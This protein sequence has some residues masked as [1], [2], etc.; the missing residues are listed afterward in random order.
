MRIVQ[1]GIAEVAAWVIAVTRGYTYPGNHV[2]LDGMCLFGRGD[3]LDVARDAVC[4]YIWPALKDGSRERYYK[5]RRGETGV[6]V[7]A[8][9]GL[10]AMKMARRVGP[11]GR[12]VAVEPVRDNFEILKL[13]RDFNQLTWLYVVN[14]AVSSHH[15]EK[16]LSFRRE[17]GPQSY[18]DKSV[19]GAGG[20]REIVVDAVSLDEVL[21]PLG[22][23]DFLSLEMNGGEYAAVRGMEDYF[24]KRIYCACRYCGDPRREAITVEL[25]L[26]GYEVSYHREG[27]IYAELSDL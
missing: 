24:P 17:N 8:Y 18:G 20:D 12:V 25:E 23:V 1:R 16:R 27:V 10:F 13:N 26:R 6:E 21:A 19:V 5:L 2:N 3:L 14:R 4:R 7:G 9:T 11:L 15:G 22:E